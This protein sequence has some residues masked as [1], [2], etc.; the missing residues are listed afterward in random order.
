M[1]EKKIRKVTA[2]KIHPG[3]PCESSVLPYWTNSQIFPAFYPMELRT[4]TR[5]TQ[6]TVALRELKTFWTLA[7]SS[8][9]Y[10]HKWG[11][12]LSRGQGTWPKWKPYDCMWIVLSLG[13]VWVSISVAMLWS[14]D[15]TH[16]Y[17]IAIICMNT[18]RCYVMTHCA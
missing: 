9:M 11:C 2:A 5:V 17:L 3:Q 14:S 12:G 6:K 8:L 13:P 1:Q 16:P 15:C 7:N 4:S 10:G 18:I